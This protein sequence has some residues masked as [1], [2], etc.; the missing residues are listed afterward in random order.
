MTEQTEQQNIN[1]ILY[2]EI[3]LIQSCITRMANNS[4]SCKS[5]NLTLIAGTF[6]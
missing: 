3:D 2:K 4:F 5:R 6:A 1:E